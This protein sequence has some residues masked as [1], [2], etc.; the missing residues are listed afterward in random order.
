MKKRPVPVDTM[1]YLTKEEKLVSVFLVAS[2]VVG[3]GI[4][5]CKK[6][7]GVVPS[8]QTPSPLSSSHQIEGRLK[9]NINSA[10]FKE[11]IKLKGIGKKTANRIIDYRQKNGPFFYKEDLIKIRGIGKAKF[12]TIK[13]SII[14][15]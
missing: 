5:F 7:F 6:K 9:V 3:S 12:E 8:L 1:S 2:F 4:S 13:D 15:E 11:L 14:I 10:S